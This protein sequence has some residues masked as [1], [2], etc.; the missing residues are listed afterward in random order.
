MRVRVC[1]LPNV[2]HHLGLLLIGSVLMLSTS[3]R[4]ASLEGLQL[5]GIAT[6]EQLGKPYYIIALYTE[7]PVSSADELMTG[8]GRAVAVMKIVSGNWTSIGFSQIWTR[9]VSINNELSGESTDIDALL[10]FFSLAKE[11]LEVGDT[12][13]VAYLPGR[14][15]KI[16]LNSETVISTPNK[17][18]FTYIV[19][20]WVGPSS[21]SRDFKAAML[22]GPQATATDRAQLVQS[23]AEFR[24]DPKRAAL[25]S[26]WQK[27]ESEN[28]AQRARAE[29]E[30]EAERER[31]AAE[32]QAAEKKRR[33]EELAAKQRA[34]AAAA[35]KLAAEKAAAA[36]A[37]AASEAERKAQLAAAQALE[38][39]KRVKK[40]DEERV[41][42]RLKQQERGDISESEAREAAERADAE[43]AKRLAADAERERQQAAAEAEAAA[44][45]ALEQSETQ[46]RAEAEARRLEQEKLDG[47]QRD[48]DEALYI[49]QVQ[50]AVL[51][52]I[53]YPEWAREFG[54]EGDI[55]ILATLDAVGNVIGTDVVKGAQHNLLVQEVVSAVNQS[56]PYGPHAG[57]TVVVPI[58]YSFQ[59]KSTRENE[60]ASGSVAQLPAQ[61]VMPP[62]LT[63]IKQ[64]SVAGPDRAGKVAEYAEL[65]R[66]KILATIE[67]PLWAKNL[68]QE[69]EAEIEVI[70]AS[71]GSVSKTRLLKETR[72][73]LL[74][75][76][77]E[78][79][80]E[81]AA[82]FPVIPPELGLDK[83]DVKF[84][85]SFGR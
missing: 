9:D 35:A 13:E 34:E 44:A 16:E 48:Y 3:L 47:L 31:L 66:A 63:M 67:Y 85:Y 49:W 74:N 58:E 30:R 33:E 40:Q 6:Y 82:P 50:R 84:T 75:K 83:V 43:G 55:K 59:L 32:Q 64:R 80:V 5:N 46:A 4:A 57:K 41:L 62:E 68:R 81:R 10:K 21:P 7:K 71:D 54:R 70:V 51:T 25:I 26:Q 69:G 22:A 45:R 18:L 52:N 77:M 15:T 53:T 56:G 14:G 11:P 39:R 27:K 17:A 1:S 2:L 29:A 72:H 78:S 23:F 12:L 42:Q 36:A 60:S 38:Q 65:V 79:A 61:P 28:A 76:E 73:N 19:N 20:V 8:D 24:T 37:A